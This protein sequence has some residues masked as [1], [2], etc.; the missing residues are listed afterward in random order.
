M[1][2]E[3]AEPVLG[4]GWLTTTQAGPLL[5]GLHSRTVLNHMKYGTKVN[6]LVIALRHQSLGGYRY[7]RAEWIAEYL[8][9]TAAPPPAN[10]AETPDSRVR[11]LTASQQRFAARYPG[12]D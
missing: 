12:N 11:R 8:A 6:G 9:A 2:A 5:C 4:T 10:P 7:T 3:V 1:A